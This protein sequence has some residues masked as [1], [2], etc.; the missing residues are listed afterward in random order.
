MTDLDNTVCH[1]S[2]CGRSQTSADY[3]IKQSFTWPSLAFMLT[4]GTSL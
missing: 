4:T 1:S 3:A 2:R